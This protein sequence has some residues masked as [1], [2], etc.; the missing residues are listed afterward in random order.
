M[1]FGEKQLG[2]VTIIEVSGDVLGGPDANE[3]HDK[4]R[5]LLNAGKKNIV[6][7]LSKV[8]YMNSSG[9]GMMT[10]ALSTVK[11]GG[12]TLALANPAERIKSLLAITKLNAVFKTYESLDEAIASLS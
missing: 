7:D 2:S 6:I 3:L 9:L 12:G 1:K 10:S 8:E 5:Q 4:L 11:N